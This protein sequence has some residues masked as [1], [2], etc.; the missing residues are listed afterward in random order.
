MACQMRLS[1]TL[2]RLKCTKTNFVSNCR[3]VHR[4]SAQLISFVQKDRNERFS[5]FNGK[6]LTFTRSLGTS[7]Q[8]QYPW[9]VNPVLTPEQTSEVLQQN[10]VSV[11][12]DEE[13]SQ[14][15]VQ[16][17]DS[18]QLFSNKPG[19]DRR[20]IAE[21]LL[22]NGILFG[23]FDGHGGT[24]CAQAVS[25]RLFNYIAAETLPFHTL[26]K[27]LAQLQS[28]E[29]N[30]LVKWHRHPNDYKLQATVDLYKESLIKYVQANLSVDVL[31]DD[32]TADVLKTAF[33]RLDNDFSTEAMRATTESLGIEPV[34]TAVTGSC[35]CVAYVD[36]QD[37]YVANVGDCRAVLGRKSE[38][39]TWEAVPLTVDHNVQNL[40]EV[41]RIK[42]G[43]PSHESTTVIK[44][45]RLLGELMP[46]RA[47]GNIRFKWTAEM[48]QKLMRTFIGYVPP[49]SYHTPPYLITTPEV[50]YRR[51]TPNDKFLILASDGLWDML[52][53][54]KAVQLVG[55]H[56]KSMKASSSYSV[57]EGSTLK[58]IMADLKERMDILKSLDTNSA[59]HLI[60]YALCGVAN[61]FDLNKLAEI[62]SL[63]DAIA[64]QHRDDMTVTVIYF[65]S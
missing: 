15:D 11:H 46:L 41:E 44:N 45:G 23:I 7:S 59:T 52:T 64:R 36:D 21:C 62:L 48:Q 33:D 4:S 56:M 65:D 28:G 25:E 38:Y 26:P 40:G 16:R 34:L 58:N 61:D 14:K 13:S 60:R 50:T 30:E 9:R 3:K 42:G 20:A 5:S 49:K 6:W 8:S 63:P 54:D 51:L 17:Y 2:I 31:D 10:E 27:I 37:L 32:S 57:E 12:F 18:N 47:F 53:N 29:A 24:A 35:A 55:E 43:H 1:L 22:S 39:G 19:E